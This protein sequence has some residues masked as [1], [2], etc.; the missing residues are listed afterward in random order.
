MLRPNI[1]NPDGSL[2]SPQPSSYYSA[3]KHSVLGIVDK[4]EGNDVKN[5][6]SSGGPG[7]A[8]GCWL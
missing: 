4:A 5:L 6:E 2:Y 1:P 3:I 7:G 8:G